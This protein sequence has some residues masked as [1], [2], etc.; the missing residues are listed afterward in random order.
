MLTKKLEMNQRLIVHLTNTMSD[1]TQVEIHYS[2]KMESCLDADY[3]PIRRQ[4][5]IL[6]LSPKNT[7]IVLE[8]AGSY[9]FEPVTPDSQAQ[10]HTLAVDNT[11]SHGD[12]MSHSVYTNQQSN[13]V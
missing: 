9:R 8:L 10:V 7:P 5:G 4:G 13:G 1:E 2:P 12:I 3:A 6:T 11:Q